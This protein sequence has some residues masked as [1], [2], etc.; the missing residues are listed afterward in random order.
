MLSDIIKNI[1]TIDK[2]N[3]KEN[4]RPMISEL[5]ERLNSNFDL[6][7]EANNVDI[8]KNNGFKLDLNII[9]N[10]FANV[11]KEP[12][13]YGDVTVS[14][15]DDEKKIIY[16][17]EIFDVG[18]V[19]VINEGNFYVTI[20]LLL[21]NLLAGNT[22]IFVNSGYMFG[23][24]NFLINEIESILKT[25][26]ISQNLF[27]I[28]VTEDYDEVLS[29]NAN[30]DLIICTG[31]HFLQ[32]MIL[33]KSKVRTI[34]TGYD[35]FDLYIESK[36]NLDFLNEILKTG[37]NINLYI[38]D[39]LNLNHSKAMLVHDINEAISQINYTGNRYSS[40]IFTSNSLNASKFINEVKSKI[41]TINT[42]PTI[43]RILD[44]KQTELMNEK[45]VI[46]PLSFNFD[47]SGVKINLNEIS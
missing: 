20:E 26:D 21:R 46:Y 9:N 19:I 18:N 38:K 4:I 32:N 37:L 16:G 25:Y 35:N 1:L 8:S 34:I 12:F 14:F 5:K 47:N 33:R 2:R 40:A 31:D 30:I 42:S 17:K 44:I 6:L 36:V 39:D 28:Y 13:A 23:S 45:I 41:I 24:N 10:I 11:L 15:K 27:Q 43:E 29:Y 22:T 7:K 3:L